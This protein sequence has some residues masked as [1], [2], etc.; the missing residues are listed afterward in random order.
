L[1]IRIERILERVRREHAEEQR[2]LHQ[3]FEIAATAPAGKE[4]RVFDLA[5]ELE[6]RHRDGFARLEHV[7]SAVDVKT[8]LLGAAGWLAFAL[9]YVAAAAL[10]V[11]GALAGELSAGDVVLTLALGTQI[12]MQFVDLVHNFRWFAEASAAMGRYRW[13]AEYAA[14][15]ARAL[16]PAEPVTVP[17]RI[18][19]GVTFNRVRFVY[20]GTHAAVLD[21]FSEHFPAGSSVAI[22]GENGAGKTTLAKLLLRFYEPTDGSILVDGIDLRR[23][24]VDEWRARLS[25]APQDYARLQLIARESV[26]VGSLPHLD[27]LA[28]VSAAVQRGAA[29]DVVGHLPHGLQTQL[30]REFDGGVDL[31][32]GQWQKLAVARSM[33]RVAP[34]VLILDEPT[35][36]LDAATE[37]SLFERF[38]DQARQAAA[39]SGA[40]TILVSHRFSTVRVADLILVIDGGRVV[41]RGTHAALMAAGGRYA[42]LYA[43]Q[44][45]GYR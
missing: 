15:T 14:D 41:E 6:R 40:V 21:E 27:D 13:L 37:H 10:V 5:D 36:S 22:V 34:L 9:G 42:E 29:E 20:P 2:A 11:R 12:N 45:R 33:M 43:L 8:A 32:I 4:V 26:G 30:G 24:A 38:A 19:S 39:A 44:A 35:A 7:D 25:T 28:A 1:G 17:E 31:S 3:L 23:F 16:Q 18:R